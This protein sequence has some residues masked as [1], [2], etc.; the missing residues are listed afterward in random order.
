MRGCQVIS[1]DYLARVCEF[2]GKVQAR[3]INL[4][5]SS[6]QHMTFTASRQNSITQEQVQTEKRSLRTKP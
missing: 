3:D 1:L 4:E 5:V 6:H 2:R